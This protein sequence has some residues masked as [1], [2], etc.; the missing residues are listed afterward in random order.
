MGTRKFAFFL[1]IMITLLIPLTG[2]AENKPFTDIAI[3]KSFEKIMLSNKDIMLEQGAH[4]LLDDND[5]T[6]LI[7][8][9]L[10]IM[11]VS[12][13]HDISI[14]TRKGEI[15]AR[16][17]ILELGGDIE[18]SVKKGSTFSENKTTL[19][20]FYQVTE[21]QVK[22]H[23]KSMPII[24]TWWSKDRDKFFVA[25][26]EINNKKN[27]V[28]KQN[29]NINKSV[30]PGIEG[31]EPYVTLLKLNP[32]FCKT[33]GVRGFIL[34]D[35]TKIIMALSTSKIKSSSVTARRIAKLKATRLL[36]EQ[37]KGIKVSSV[38]RIVDK[39]ALVLSNNGSRHM[40][41]SEFMSVQKE[42]VSGF[43]NTLPVVAS[44]ND[45]GTV[46]IV[47]GK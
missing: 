18:I 40:I 32:D 45:S 27:E 7:G 23:V 39:E 14:L 12:G 10:V 43:I 1:I 28:I 16:K 47:I 35:N 21:T 31:K 15:L 42:H 8:I 25:L 37:K 34:E 19:S 33:G 44:W 22:G 26:G 38:E 29:M 3:E 6:A 11:D 20:L 5:R 41:L 2:E 30:L 9:G 46:F 4:V 24:G 13:D 36:L 17:A